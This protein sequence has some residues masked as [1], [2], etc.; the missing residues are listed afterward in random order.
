MKVNRG[1]VGQFCKSRE[2]HPRALAEAS[3][4]VDLNEGGMNDAVV[5]EPDGFSYVFVSISLQSEGRGYD[6]SVARTCAFRDGHAPRF[7]RLSNCSA[8]PWPNYPRARHLDSPRLGPC[9]AR[10]HRLVPPSE[11]VDPARASRHAAP[12]SGLRPSPEARRL[13]AEV[14]TYSA[15]ASPLIDSGLASQLGCSARTATPAGFIQLSPQGFALQLERR[16]ASQ[17]EHP[18]ASSPGVPS[19]HLPSDK[20]TEAV[21]SCPANYRANL[22]ATWTGS[23][24]EELSVSV[25]EEPS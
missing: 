14:A 17:L 25:C 8:R 2:G 15:L 23:G 13:P 6:W 24:S 10:R 16:A 5:A 19:A 3:R 4:A 18:P 9:R 21:D 20:T 11:V 22:M 12:F 1:Y 7:P